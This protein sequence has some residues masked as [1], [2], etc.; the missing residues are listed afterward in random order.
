MRRR[1]ISVGVACA[2][3]GLLAYFSRVGQDVPQLLWNGADN[4]TLGFGGIIVLTENTRT[5][6]VQ[7][8]LSSDAQDGAGRTRLSKGRQA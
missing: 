4:A 3:L 2:I 6:R 8:L 5:W 1:H 7:G